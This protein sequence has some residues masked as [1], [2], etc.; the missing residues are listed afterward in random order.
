ML[1][2]ASWYL[3][4]VHK[5]QLLNLFEDITRINDVVWNNPH[6]S[7]SASNAAAL[8]IEEALEKLPLSDKLANQLDCGNTPKL[9]ARTIVQLTTGDNT[10][11]TTN[12][13][14]APVAAFDSSLDA[15]YIEIGNMHMQGITPEQM[16]DGLQVV[17]DANL[18]KGGT[19]DSQNK[20][21][22]PD[23]WEELFAPEPK[24]Q[25]ILDER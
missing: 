6:G 10:D 18:M 2:Y 12:E 5:K 7:Y 9:L 11:G 22:K 3:T 25:A 15:I 1:N 20:V 21:I 17:H 16:V 13:E 19:K 8:V 14:V 4:V 23:Q 24:L